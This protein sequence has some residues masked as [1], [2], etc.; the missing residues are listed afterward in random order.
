MLKNLVKQLFATARA[1][2]TPRK[3]QPG[4]VADHLRRGL[5]EQAA[6]RYRD[7]EAA[8]REALTQIPAHADALHLLGHLLVLQE[9]YDEAAEVL[10]ELVATGSRAAEPWFNFGKAL[11]GQGRLADAAAAFR[12]AISLNSGF[13][14][15]LVSCGDVLTALERLDEAEECYRQAID[16]EPGFAAAYH[17]YGNLLHGAGRIDEAVAA[18]RRAIALKPDLVSAHSNLVYALNFSPAVAPERVYAEHLEWARRHAEP[19]KTEYRPHGN[20][21]VPHRKLRIGY[22]SP[23]FRDH[24]VTWFFEPALKHHDR[25]E[26]V[27]HLYSDVQRPDFRTARLRSYGDEWC[28][29]SALS[30]DALAQRVRSDQIDILV[31]LTGH[32]DGHR[33][34]AFA[35]KPAPVQV[36][37]NGYAN[38]TGMDAMDYR[39]TDHHADPAGT[40]ERWHSERL[41]R[42]PEIYMAFDPPEN[43]PAVNAPPVQVNGYVTFGSFNAFAK[44]TPQVIEVWSRL[45]HAVPDSRLLMLTVPDGRARLNLVRAFAGHGVPE[46]RLRLVGRLP[47]A[48]FLEAHLEADLALDPF[49]FNGTTTTCH[50]LWMG[51]PVVA[52]AGTTHAG[53]VGVSILTNSGLAQLVA[54]DE[55][56]YVALAAALAGDVSRLRELR[57]GMREKILSSPVT[58]GR[59]LT[60]FLEIAYRKM[61]EDYCREPVSAGR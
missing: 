42:L 44:I 56:G 26:F 61:W 51:V 50:T 53:R 8:Y 23:N 36:T 10:H 60:R 30:D 49:P 35:R 1:D 13:T 7:A 24:P 19:L 39:I 46:A 59:R 4:A 45:L 21:R 38:T 22:V 12:T 54:C 29:T 16:G 18:Y 20:P 43:A 32:T 11:R 33:L 27:I 47:F 6:G 15:A 31:D 17:N 3:T 14:A 52:L 2:N 37:W 5:A 57:G 55:S 41:V 58:D 28:D 9:R 25:K 34:L 48:A 40:T